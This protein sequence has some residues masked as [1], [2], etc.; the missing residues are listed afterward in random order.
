M[1]NSIS[2]FLLLLCFALLFQNCG[3]SGMRMSYKHAKIPNDVNF[4]ITFNLKSMTTKSRS[5]REAFN[6][7]FL[8]Q[9][10][11]DAVEILDMQAMF[12]KVLNAG[13]DLQNKA[14]FFGKFSKSDIDSYFGFSFLLEDEKQ[15]EEALSQ[16]KN[17]TPIKTDKELKYTY[18]NKAFL[19]WK[20]VTALYLSSDVNLPEAKLLELFKKM[21][22]TPANQSLETKN[23]EFATLDARLFDFGFWIDQQNINKMN[24]DLDDIAQTSPVLRELS[25]VSNYTTGGIT[26]E[27]GQMLLETTANLNKDLSKKYEQIL[28]E[29][30]QE[31][32]LSQIPIQKPSILFGLGLGMKDLYDLLKEDP[33]F[34]EGDYA[35]KD[36]NLTSKELFDMLGGDIVWA[37]EDLHLDVFVRNPKPEFVLALSINNRKILNKVLDK[38]TQLK[39][40]DDRGGGLYV[41]EQGLPTP[42]YLLDKNNTLY[43]TMTEPL[44]EAITKNKNLLDEKHIK[45]ASGNSFIVYLDVQ[46]LYRQIPKEWKE[47]N[48]EVKSF[49][50]DILPELEEIIINTSAFRN[51]TAT[52]KMTVTFKSKDKNALVLL[53]DIIKKYNQ[54][55][56]RVSSLVK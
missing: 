15:F 27:N 35:L 56:K 13:L 22:N 53:T 39:T 23:K 25:R 9:M 24:A 20:G 5:W 46:D 34:R 29:G 37:F 42:I 11:V 55:N 41:I 38:A 40:L 3:E 36:V 51:Y 17:A 26:F 31:K 7:D 52:G 12:D 49:E 19:G 16:M 47:G 8:E 30:I 18:R 1:K 48:A 33:N 4:V 32:I 44:K 6:R 54:S 2:I 43:F 28:K 14:Y 50:E 10:D 45:S 21:M